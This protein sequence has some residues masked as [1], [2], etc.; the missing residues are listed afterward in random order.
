MRRDERGI[1]TGHLLRLVLVLGLLGL[2]AVEGASVLFARLN[3]QDAAESAAA[4]AASRFRDTGSVADAR[5]AAQDDT[6]LVDRNA[7]LRSF[8]VRPDGS[9]RVVVVRRAS[10]IFIQHIGFLRGFTVARGTAVGQPPTF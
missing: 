8:E 1:V 2:V 6:V 4:V 5:Q 7:E 9:V 3:A 10:T